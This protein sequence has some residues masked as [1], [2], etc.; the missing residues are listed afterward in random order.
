MSPHG[1]TGVPKEGGES[2]RKK[3]V[4]LGVVTSLIGTGV[5]IGAMVPAA[6]QQP[7][8]SF[9]LCDRNRGGYSKDIDV[10]KQGFSAGDYF[11]EVDT[12]RRPKSGAKVGRIVVKTTFVRVFRKQQDARFIADFQAAFPNGKIT[13]YGS[14]RFSSFQKG[15][16]GFAI[17]GGTGTYN[18]VRGGAIVRNGRCGGKAGVL[19]TFNLA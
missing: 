3:L 11:V 10:G 2:M 14:A 17:T 7:G 15:G 13:G 9:T 8:T 6:S 19:I 5:V 12:L 4:V 16:S 18:E 1:D